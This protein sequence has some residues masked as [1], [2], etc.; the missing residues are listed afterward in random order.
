MAHS[1]Y[2]AE[3]HCTVLIVRCWCWCIDDPHQWCL[4]LNLHYSEFCIAQGN[5]GDTDGIVQYITLPIC[6]TCLDEINRLPPQI[7]SIVWQWLSATD[8]CAFQ[9]FFF[10]LLFMLSSRICDCCV[11]LIQSIYI[12]I[13]LCMERAFWLVSS[14]NKQKDSR[15][16]C[17]GW[18]WPITYGT[19]LPTYMHVAPLCKYIRNSTFW[20]A[21][22][23]SI[24]FQY[25]LSGRRMRKNSNNKFVI[26]IYILYRVWSN[27]KHT[28]ND[29]SVQMSVWFS[30]KWG[31]LMA[32]LTLAPPRRLHCNCIINRLG[33]YTHPNAHTTSG[34]KRTQ[35]NKK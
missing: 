16:I 4:S 23:V 3:R 33:T 10:Y 13:L 2:N 18:W 35:K 29:T 17:V 27:R 25:D 30:A 19:P 15:V 24:G 26:E 6:Y 32:R 28:P 5:I 12:I 34:I 1:I 14:V 21:H 7:F 31:A 22:V 8:G 11:F 9:L 20:V